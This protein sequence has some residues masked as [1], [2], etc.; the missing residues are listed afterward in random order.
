MTIF[1]EII[2][3]NVTINAGIIREKYTRKIREQYV[4]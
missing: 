4:S 2:R 1:A 3:V